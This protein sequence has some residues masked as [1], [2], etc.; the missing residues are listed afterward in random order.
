MFSHQPASKS[1]CSGTYERIDALRKGGSERESAR[2][3]ASNAPDMASEPPA[4]TISASVG[5][6]SAFFLA[7]DSAFDSN[8]TP[9]RCA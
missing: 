8:L 3:A 7:R 4:W 2:A 1:C 6:E 5:A 9:S